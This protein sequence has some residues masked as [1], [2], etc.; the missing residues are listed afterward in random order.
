MPYHIQRSGSGFKVV[1][2]KGGKRPGHQFSKKPQSR[3]RALAQLRAI[4]I[5]THGG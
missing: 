2:G 1:E 5:H 3:K 4:Q